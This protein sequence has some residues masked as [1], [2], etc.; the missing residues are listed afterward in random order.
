MICIF[1]GKRG[2]IY[3][4]LVK[5]PQK[6]G[7]LEIFQRGDSLVLQ[8]SNPE[9]YMDGNPIEGKITVEIWLLKEKR[10]LPLQTESLKEEIFT[11]KAT[12]LE[13]LK[14]ENFAE[15]QDQVGK[16]SRGLTY[17]YK[18]SADEL[19]QMSFV[20]GLRVKTSKNRESSFSELKRIIP[21]S[22]PLPPSGLQ[23]K[24]VENSVTLE[25]NR[26]ETNIDS[27]T[28]P[29]VVGYNVY[30][31]SDF[32]EFHRINPTLIEGTS[33][34]DR[35]IIYNV[36]YRYYV[37][38]SDTSSSPYTESDNSFA[39]DIRTE[40]TLIPAVPTG[41]VAVAGEDFVSLSWDANKERDIAGYRVWRKNG[42][43]GEFVAVSEL[44]T[45]NVYYDPKVE[46]AQRYLYAITA[47][48]VNGNESQRSK[49][50][51]VVLGRGG[52]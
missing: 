40:D 7:N 32:E 26:P 50:V 34:V 4:P 13:A 19:S 9:S 43:E 44:V 24:M 42:S 10:E 30:R 17:I 12:L 20:F 11:S 33:F 29:N 48:D 1:C 45:E 14:Q 6:V 47:L 3:P 25:W 52:L 2:P 21:K 8:W 15:F 22:L 28:P 49:A 38:A 16:S 41:L 35:D 36:T 27:S 5:I 31:E 46:K 39:T 51:S 18:I 37:R 23:A